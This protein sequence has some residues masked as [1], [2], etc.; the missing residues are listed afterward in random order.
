M[1]G[2]GKCH[3]KCGKGCY[4]A[5]GKFSHFKRL[6]GPAGTGVTGPDQL[7]QKWKI[8]HKLCEEVLAEMPARVGQ[9]IVLDLFSGGESY[10]AAVEAAGYRYVPVD[11]LTLG[12]RPASKAAGEAAQVATLFMQQKG[13]SLQGL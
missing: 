7:M 11:I 9:D 4:K 13:V 5:N 10:R 3:Q 1:T 6:G 2:D 12:E 8:P